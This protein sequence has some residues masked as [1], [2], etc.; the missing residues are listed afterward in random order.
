MAR[1]FRSRVDEEIDERIDGRES[2]GVNA[3]RTAGASRVAFGAILIF[4]GIQSLVAGDF[5]V[6]WQPVPEGVPARAV[7][8]DLCALVSLASGIGLLWRRTARLA[9]G[10]LLALFVLWFLA[11]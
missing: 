8:V 1:V 11:W 9:A 7:L 5:G 2:N 4:L 10:V 3:M 6:V